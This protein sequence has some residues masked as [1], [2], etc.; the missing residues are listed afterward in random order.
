MACAPRA[1]AQRRKVAL[2]E[3]QMVRATKID[4]GAARQNQQHVVCVQLSHECAH[5]IMHRGIETGDKATENQANRFARAFLLPR[6]SFIQEF[7]RGSSLN[8]KAIFAL[9]L[10]WSA[11]SL[12]GEA[13]TRRGETGWSGGLD[14]NSLNVARGFRRFSEI[15]CFG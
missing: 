5:L 10:R 8:W 1:T 3:E 6:A 15:A 2:I 9:K 11:R 7:P 4:A 13:E 12:A 14:S